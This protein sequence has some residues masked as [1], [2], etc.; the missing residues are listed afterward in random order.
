[1]DYK[2]YNDFQLTLMTT[3]QIYCV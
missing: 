1:M 3:G 2:N